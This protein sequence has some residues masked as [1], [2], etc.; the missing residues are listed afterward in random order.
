MA[1]RSKTP[2][3][4]LSLGK[5]IVIGV[6]AVVLLLVIVFQFGGPKEN[7]KLSPVAPQKTAAEFRST[8]SSGAK[9]PETAAKRPETPWPTFS[10]AEVVSSNPFTLPEVLRPIPEAAQTLTPSSTIGGAEATVLALG[11]ARDREMR[12]RQAEFIA[13]LRARGV[14]MILRSPRGS[15]ARIGELSLRVGDVHEGLRVEEIGTN[16]ILFAPATATVE[17]QPE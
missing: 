11:S 3:G 4:G 13:G 8:G 10:V 2:R 1:K 7:H 9:A 5:V 15:V 17:G 16:G 6:L 12:R 14:D